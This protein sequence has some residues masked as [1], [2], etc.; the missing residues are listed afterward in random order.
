MS[1][2]PVNAV[3]LLCWLALSG[4]PRAQDA[5]GQAS[6]ELLRLKDDAKPE[7]I[8]TLAEAKSQPAADGLAKAF[9]VMASVL[10]RLEIVRALARFE[11]VPKAEA[12]A[13]EKLAKVAVTSEDAEVAD[14]AIRGLAQS[15]SLG[16]QALRQIVDADVS[17][18]VR[19]QALRAHV[20]LAAPE[21]AAWYRFVW[22]LKAEHRKNAD[23]TVQ[24]PELNS[25]REIAF[26]ALVPGLTEAELVETLRNEQNP[27]IRR[28]A[29]AAMLAR[30]MPKTSEMAKWLLE[31]VDFPGADRAEAARIL[32]K[33]EGAKAAA[34]FLELAKKRDVTPEDLR[35]TMADLIVELDDDA[36]N[37]RLIKLIG[38]GR[39]HERVFVLHA[40]RRVDDPKALLAIRKE[41]QA[42]DLEV[43]R[44]AAQVLAQRRDK[45]SLP[46]LRALLEKSKNPQDQ[47]L[48][49]EAIG[50]FEG[51]ASK[52]LTELEGYAANADRDVRNAA[53]EQLVKAKDPGRLPALVKAL[54]HPD[55]STRLLVA[56]G[57]A[58][59]GDKR[60]VPELIARLEREQ[61]RLARTISAS[62]W[63]LTGQPFEGD[64]GS[65]KSWWAAEGAT[66]RIIR[67][68]ELAKAASDLDKRRL[69]TRTRSGARFFGIKLETHR[70]VFIIDTSGSMLESVNAKVGGRR[71]VSRIDVAKQELSQCIK[72]L[73][74]NALFNVF[75]FSSGIGQWLKGGVGESG[76]Q[77]RE[78]ALTWVERL[79]A[80]GATNLYD[81]LELA[82]ED[83][84]VDTMFVLSD[85]E[86]TAG[87]IIDPH[88]IRKE[89]AVWNEHR[90]VK[91]HTIAIGGNLEI[92]EWL[93]TDSGGNHIRIR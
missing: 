10:M 50:A 64:V 62:L 13:V 82:F 53:L 90:H 5:V 3:M 78:A 22:N 20:T 54:E 73:D 8:A 63:K 32:V 51:S 23:G 37:K 36:T 11:G 38:A 76:A 59:L 40:T 18:T 79:G 87:A 84:E 80:A 83:K 21:D 89:V 34:G 7:L 26:G 27:K 2:Y 56:E 14:A 48:A 52:W 61:G 69:R 66:F 70:V 42:K 1:R 9:D 67:P 77:G 93:A 68:D 45:D 6:A 16:K 43:R 28:K 44:A 4:G 19:D 74:S 86:P 57:L 17:D 58:E 65:W 46:A 35:E 49:I 15:R 24:A 31:R 29:L 39:P 60:V 30:E 85:G 71:G 72:G 33:R 41:L 55:W 92:L 75:A 25:I 88:R 12:V 81:V 91:I 47:S